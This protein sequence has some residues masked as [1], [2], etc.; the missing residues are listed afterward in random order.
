MSKK[1]NINKLITFLVLAISHKIGGMVNPNEIYAS[2]YR[3]EYDNYIKLANEISFEENFNSYD[4]KEIREKLRGKLKEELE[5]KDF[6][7]NKKFD[8]MEEETEKTLSSLGI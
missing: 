4:K 6:I 1:D 8:I 2:K 3:K 5:R 7:D